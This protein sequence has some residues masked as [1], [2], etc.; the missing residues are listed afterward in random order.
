MP[1]KLSLP[2][3]PELVKHL[4]RKPAKPQSRNHA[5]CCHSGTGVALCV[6]RLAN[7]SAFEAGCHEMVKRD[8]KT[9]QAS[10]RRG[11]LVLLACAVLGVVPRAEA[12]PFLLNLVS[13]DSSDYGHAGRGGEP[14][15]MLGLRVR[16][17]IVSGPAFNY[18]G[19]GLIG[20]ARTTFPTLSPWT[21]SRVAA[22]LFAAPKFTNRVAGASA[23]DVVSVT[24][25]G[26]TSVTQLDLGDGAKLSVSDS[27]GDALAD[28]LSSS[29]G[30]APLSSSN[31]PSRPATPAVANDVNDSTNSADVSGQGGPSSDYNSVSSLPGSAPNGVTDESVKRIFN[32]IASGIISSA[33]EDTAHRADD[34][35]AAA[36]MVQ[37]PEPATLLLLASALALTANR[38]RRQQH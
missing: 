11:V 31:V 35:A 25:A 17:P 1:E 30:D 8:S 19:N 5:E 15:A 26:L 24:S 37:N 27:V 16:G 33:S 7:F 10:N 21:N 22:G 32:D 13:S 3:V 28:A 36:N 9:T 23:T 18:R 4:S 29:G 2:N 6:P 38:L 14:G 20:L 34:F 12:S